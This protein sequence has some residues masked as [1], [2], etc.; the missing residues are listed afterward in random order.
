MEQDDGFSF[1]IWG[2]LKE[3]DVAIRTETT[4]DFG[5]WGCVNGQSL[6]ADGHFT[7]VAD[8]D[9]GL[10]APD[11]G[12][13]WAGRNWTQN[14]MFLD[15]GLLSGGVR[16][17]AQFAM[18]FVSVYVWQQLVQEAIGT[19][20]FDDVIGRQ[21]GR[22]ALLPVVVT[23]FD[24]AFGLGRGC[25]TKGHAVEVQGGSELGEGVWG[26]SKEKGV[27][28]HIE[29]QRQSVSLKGSRQEVEVR[30]EGFGAIEAGTGIVAGGI[31]QQ[32]EQDLFVR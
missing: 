29:C 19:L 15:E 22:E 8:A 18:D 4:D 25:I 16:G 24:F 1:W 11:K 5:T 9:F 26:V 6:V 32:V 28:V 7:I 13:P 12:P 17:G 20:Q 23:A 10:L 3:I 21:Q 14:G 30:Q 31:V 2:M 27:V